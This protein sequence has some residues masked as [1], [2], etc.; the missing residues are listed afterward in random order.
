MLKRYSNE[1]VQH[2]TSS[3]PS[4]CLQN[5][6]A[7][8]RQQA[9]WLSNTP[10]LTSFSAIYST[11]TN[12]AVNLWVQIAPSLLAYELKMLQV[13]QDHSRSFKITLMSRAR[14]SSYQLS[15]VGLICMCLSCTANAIFNVG[16][17]RDL[18]IW[19]DHSRSLNMA[20]I[21]RSCTTSY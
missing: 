8:S 18:E 14:V 17:W 12:T 6:V 11:L 3:L 16:Y 15:I 7:E 1:S 21:D 13:T 10:Q 2:Y 9:A 20:P 19:V 5:D 4:N